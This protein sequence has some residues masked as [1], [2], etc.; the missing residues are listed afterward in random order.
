MKI[1]NMRNYIDF[2]SP[3]ENID[4][5]DN[6]VYIHGAAPRRHAATTNEFDRGVKSAK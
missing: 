4:M 5:K 6:I 1:R 3:N 2:I